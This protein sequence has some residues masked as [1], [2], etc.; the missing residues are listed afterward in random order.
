MPKSWHDRHAVAKI[1]DDETK[2]FYKS[3]VADRKP[4]FMRYIYPQ[5]MRQYNTYVK[6]TEQ[7]AQREFRMSIDELKSLS[8]SELTERQ[9]EFLR[10]YDMKMPV[11]TSDCVMNKICRRFEEEFDGFIGDHSK[12]VLI[13]T[14]REEF[15]DS[16]PFDYSI[17][18][19]GKEYS[20]D[21]YYAVKKLYDEYNKRLQNYK[22]FTMYERVDKFEAIA[23]KNRMR[24]EYIRE[25][26][27]VCSNAQEL[28]DII[29]D[30]CYSKSAT[31]K[32]A[33]DMCPH[34]IINNMLERNEYNISYPT[35]DEEGDII[36]CGER[37]SLRTK[38][39]SMEEEDEH[40]FEGE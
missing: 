7:N 17:M 14:S 29:I 23:E 33:W 38:K 28:C 18:K 11:G 4:Y 24:D 36:F 35:L 30:V 34:D 3:I 6:S 12:S 22:V 25:C 39:I 16:K 8:Y 31:R 15:D 40:N 32:F 19:S 21:Q 2:S 10:Y 9:K 20:R 37:Y 26:L 27:S 1:D 13:G 5:L